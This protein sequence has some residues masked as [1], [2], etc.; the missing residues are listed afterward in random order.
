MLEVFW[1]CWQLGNTFPIIP[2]SLDIWDVSDSGCS[3][4]GCKI[5]HILENNHTVV[6]TVL[7]RVLL[8]Y[9]VWGDQFCIWN[10][11]VLMS[12]ALSSL[13]LL[14]ASCDNEKCWVIFALMSCPGEW[15]L[16]QL[17][18]FHVILRGIIQV[19]CQTSKGCSRKRLSFS[20]S[21][22]YSLVTS[23]PINKNTEI[24][25]SVWFLWITA[26][27][28]MAHNSALFKC[29]CLSWKTFSYN[30][31]CSA[32]SQYCVYIYAWPSYGTA[33]TWASC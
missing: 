31:C 30:Y 13:M 4:L 1:L 15:K 11:S 20:S 26:N 28:T 6:E 19:S 25:T 22:F 7:E 29:P 14:R 3:S 5:S 2:L 12:C 23:N 16:K 9:I 21:V 17:L 8:V 33:E 32:L 10:W 24:Q 27:L 18:S